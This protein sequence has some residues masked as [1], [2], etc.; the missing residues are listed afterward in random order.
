[1]EQQAKTGATA[2]KYGLILAGV[3]IALTLMLFVQDMHTTINYTTI[4]IGM[5]LP[6]LLI[7]LGSIFGIREFKKKNNGMLS[8]GQGIKIGVGTAL[9]YGVVALAF[10]FLMAEVIDP[11]MATKQAASLETFMTE[12]GAPYESIEA[13]RAKI[14]NPNYAQSIGGGLLFFIFLGLLASFI[15]SLVMRKKV[16][17]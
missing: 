5:V 6:F 17:E 4:I 7:L 14:E 1:M 13:E 15:P 10:N 12:M 16:E 8:V 3:S 2:L 11:D 9:I